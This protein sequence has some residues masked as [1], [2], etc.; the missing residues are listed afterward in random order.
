MS[1]AAAVNVYH[2]LATLPQRYSRLFDQ[3]QKDSF[4]F[5]L[6]WFNNFVSTVAVPERRLRIYA[7]ETQGEPLAVLLMQQGG[8]YGLR[9]LNPLSNYYTSLFSPIL[10]RRD[11]A[12]GLAALARAI[13]TEAWDSVDLHPLAERTAA[14]VSEAFKAAGMFC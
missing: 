14:K 1:E 5:S 10:D 12:G 8:A 11:E 4:Y 3:A 9:E 6:P 13:A 7:A 2:D